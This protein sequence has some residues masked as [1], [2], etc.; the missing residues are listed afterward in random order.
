M[1]RL[2][3]GLSLL[4]GECGAAAR[5]CGGRRAEAAATGPEPATPSGTHHAMRA[6]YITVDDDA[7]RALFYTFVESAGRPATDPLVL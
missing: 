7:G 4:V 3:P 1:L 6:G 5:A 2:P